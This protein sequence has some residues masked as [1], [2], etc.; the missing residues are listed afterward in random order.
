MT[1]PHLSVTPS[2]RRA[3]ELGL[4]APAGLPAPAGYSPI[5]SKGLIVPEMIHEMLSIQ[6]RD[7]QNTSICALIYCLLLYLTCMCLSSNRREAGIPFPGICGGDTLLLHLQ[8]GSNEMPPLICIEAA[9]VGRIKDPAT[10]PLSAAV[11]LA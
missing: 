10:Q 4:A 9:C 2:G 6:C 1:P 11:L 8:L 5:E 3:S 7:R